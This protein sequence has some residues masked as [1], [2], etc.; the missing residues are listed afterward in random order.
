MNVCRQSSKRLSPI[1]FLSLVFTKVNAERT[2]STLARDLS[3]VKEEI[4]MGIYLW[5]LGAGAPSTWVWGFGWALS[6]E[7]S[8][9][10]LLPGGVGRSRAG[11]QSLAACVPPS[12]VWDWS[13]EHPGTRPI[14]LLHSWWTRVGRLGYATAY[15]G[16]PVGSP[17]IVMKLV[18][19]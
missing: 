18:L 17:V 10:R 8:G 15:P 11:G 5:G 19:A 4:R 12:S 13:A 16:H 1:L 7:L 6:A 14:Q 3:R 9:A 2:L